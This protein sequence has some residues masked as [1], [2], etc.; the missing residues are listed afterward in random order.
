MPR[1]IPIGLDDVN[2]L[3]RTSGEVLQAVSRGLDIAAEQVKDKLLAPTKDWRDK[4]EITIERGNFRREIGTD[5][6]K[7]TMVVLGTKEHPIYPKRAKV[8]RLNRRTPKTIPF[9]FTTTG[10]GDGE[11]QYATKVLKNPGISPRGWDELIEYEYGDYSGGGK[12][13]EIVQNEINNT[14]R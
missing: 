5:H 2:W 14:V 10:G 7:Y 9:S 8:L 11:I 1:I 4:P 12:L 6:D 13:A 3:N